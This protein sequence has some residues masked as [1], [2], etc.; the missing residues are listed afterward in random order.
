MNQ[1]DY[2]DLATLLSEETSPSE[3]ERI[4]TEALGKDVL[5]GLAGKKHAEKS[6]TFVETYAKQTK[7][8]QL[9]EIIAK[10]KP[11][12]NLSPWGYSSGFETTPDADQTPFITFT[13]RKVEW[14][15]VLH[16]TGQ[17]YLFDGPAGY[18][19]TALL[20]K[21]EEEFRRRKWYCAYVSLEICSTFPEI[22]QHLRQA[23]Q[24][25]F[26]IHAE[27]HRTG[28]ELGSAITAQQNNKTGLV[29]LFDVDHI[30]TSKL[31]S[32]L[33]ELL[34]RFVPG[35][36]E[37]LYADSQFFQ[38]SPD[39]F[40]VVIA[41]RYL[42]P[43]IDDLNLPYEF[44][45]THLTPFNYHAVRDVSANYLK[46]RLLTGERDEF[47]AHLLFY[48]GGHPRCIA[49][50]LLL[51]KDCQ[52]SATEFFVRRREDI[53]R[54]AYEEANDRVRSSIDKKWRR[55]FDA[56]CLYRRFDSELV[57]QLM[58]RGVIWHGLGKDA[59]NVII[60][61][62]QLCLVDRRI[63]SGYRHLSDDITR[64]LLMLRLRYDTAPGEFSDLCTQ[65]KHFCINRLNTPGELRHIWTIEALFSYLQANV[66][67]INDLSD[68]QA[69]RQ[70]FFADEL[71][72]ILNLLSK[73][74]DA[75]SECASLK[76]LLADDWEFHFTVNYYLRDTVYTNEMYKELLQ[77]IEKFPRA[78]AE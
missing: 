61:L 41:G 54:I 25:Q 3:L 69:L 57:E 45:K 40:R 5:N 30:P 74:Q 20:K 9:L 39:N 43:K 52:L 11:D 56:L 63:D 12:L 71:P 15:L 46:D 32:T 66:A 62:L 1:A 4:I 53:E 59:Y 24:V 49:R 70:R 67:N 23:L 19:K 17:Y 55:T 37:A 75:R 44:Q 64:R 51:F 10:N 27:P 29:L 77:H 76:R 47:A 72:V 26:K 42:A 2:N 60:N 6:S 18:G 50:M 31:H 7:I 33:T 36:W 14:E 35:V 13:N 58:G 38:D 65:A 78:M 34:D 68:R 48:S 8:S 22:V 21:L 16:P 28:L 73:N